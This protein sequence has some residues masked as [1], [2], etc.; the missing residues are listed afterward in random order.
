MQPLNWTLPRPLDMRWSPWILLSATVLL[1]IAPTYVRMW[2]TL[3][4]EEAYEYGAM[5][6]GIFWWLVWKGRAAL[7][8]PDARPA[9]GAGSAL[10]VL[11]LL[12]YYIGRSQSI[13]V[14]E[15]GSHLPV[16]MGVVLV[17][18]G[19]TALRRLWFAFVFLCFMIPLPGFVLV[20]MTSQ[21]KDWVSVLAEALLYQAGY[22]IAR[23]GVV[24][25]IGQ[26]PMLVADAC[27]GLN[28]I[29]TLTAMG[30]LYMHLSHSPGRVRNA[31]LLLAIV[32]MAFLANLVRVILLM[33]LTY[34]VGY[35]AGQG[36]MHGASGILLFVVALT[37]LMGLDA[38]LRR[39]P[40]LRPA[41]EAPAAEPAPVPVPPA[42]ASMPTRDAGPMWIAVGAVALAAV[43]SHALRP[44]PADRPA[45]SLAEAIPATFG[46]WRIDPD[47]APLA[48]TPDVQANLDRIY[49][50]IV[51]RTYVDAAGRRVM[52]VMAY[53]GDQSD[54]LKAHRQEVC[55][56]AQG[57]TVRDVRTQLVGF[58]TTEVPLVR[59]HALHV[60]RSEPVSY[61]F[62][63]GDTVA[64]GRLE[65]LWVQVRYGLQGR[66][67]DGLLVRVSTVD[68][69]PRR[70][71]ALQD[72]F[73]RQLAAAVPE[74]T[75]RRLGMGSRSSGL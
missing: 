5:M 15:L 48:P 13:A 64:L 25:T 69:D 24:I 20:A 18:G 32:P 62:T 39:V 35:D 57:F 49:D 41:A 23:D 9:P 61:W 73:L 51:S 38:L 31:L 28:S 4:S 53:G 42:G 36:F 8:A 12:V 65:R 50:E 55:Y 2:G 16:L 3:W 72:D 56:T 34:H 45:V 7:H 21:L 59:M 37:G 71:Y 44:E 10:M 54:S 17:I 1:I 33:L 14:F 43:F 67:P 74:A 68:D 46:T 22:P 66:V 30:L 70:S 47:V 60:S 27:S 75:R 40:G 63:M 19:W 29:Y 58:G 11:G 26:Y 52:L 6:A